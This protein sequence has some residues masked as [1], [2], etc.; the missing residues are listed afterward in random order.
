[1]PKPC[2]QCPDHGTTTV[3]RP[4]L[5]PLRHQ[6]PPP[7][8]AIRGAY[9]R[10]EFFLS[11]FPSPGTTPPPLRSRPPPCSPS[12][13]TASG[14]GDTSTSF[15]NL[16]CSSPTVPTAPATSTPACCR[17]FP[18]ADPLHHRQSH[19]VSS[20]LFAAPNPDC[21]PIGLLFDPS[22]LHLVASSRRDLAGNHRPVKSGARPCFSS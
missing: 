22:S 5:L 13:V 17:S 21:H 3:F 6:R 2:V 18:A 20:L 9:H 14:L 4:W 10:G 1:V 11:F 7:L 16:H 19:P 12:A 15:H 8:T